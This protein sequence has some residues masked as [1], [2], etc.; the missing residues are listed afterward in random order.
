[1]R[2]KTILVIDDDLN[3]CKMTEHIFVKE[4][5]RVFTASS[6]LDGMR[7]FYKHRPDLIILDIMMPEEDGWETC[8]NIR[9][10]SDVPIIMLTALKTD[11][12]ITRGLNNGADDFVTKP[13]SPGVLLARARAVLRRTEAPTT[14]GKPFIYSD[15]YLT[16]DLDARRV[17]IN[18]QLVKMTPTEF[19]L[20]AYL[21]KNPGRVLTLQQILENVWGWEYQDSLEYVHVYMS[22]L[23][24][25]I[26][27]DPKQPR[28]IMTEY[29]IG[30]RFEKQ[31]Q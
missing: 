3:I 11:E 13:F 24:K 26:E 29:G 12:D 9:K 25:K 20:L 10:F 22:H 23:R 2:D 21:A 5:A 7:K 16:I 30:Y 15:G 18:G 8:R 31:Y 27:E 4:G 17:I 14:V 6:G 19:Q 28:Y 1:M